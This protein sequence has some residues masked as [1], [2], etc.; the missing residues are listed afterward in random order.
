MLKGYISLYT[1]TKLIII[2]IRCE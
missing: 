1:G 2:L